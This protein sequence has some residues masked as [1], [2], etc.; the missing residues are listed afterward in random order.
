MIILLN[1]NDISC[2]LRNR[3]IRC[4]F[5]LS[6]VKSTRIRFHTE[7]S[8]KVNLFSLFFAL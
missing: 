6:K 7:T 1:E 2:K 8:F 4:L 3:F 5:G